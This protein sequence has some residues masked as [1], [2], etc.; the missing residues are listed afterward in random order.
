MSTNNENVKKITY[1]AVKIAK[2]AWEKN[3]G[4]NT[5]HVERVS[6]ALLATTII[7]KYNIEV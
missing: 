6:I 7:K 4:S 1:E 5:M 2:E 3:F